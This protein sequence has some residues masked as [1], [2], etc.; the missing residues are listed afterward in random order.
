MTTDQRIENLEK[1]LAFARRLNRWLLAAVGLALGVW[2]LAGTFGPTMAAAPAAVAA[3][4]EVRAN[5]FVVEDENGKA[6][7]L[8]DATKEKVLELLDEKGNFLGALYMEKNGTRLY[9]SQVQT[10]TFMITDKTS[11]VPRIMMA[12][13]RETQY[14]Y[15]HCPF[16][17]V[18]APQREPAVVAVSEATRGGQVR[19]LNVTGQ[20]GL[21]YEARPKWY[22]NRSPTW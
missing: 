13:F 14:R 3:V 9:L 2:I 19:R 16:L 11:L 12:G 20:R 17:R 10:E 1:G 22:D 5:R 6:R 21:L 15:S 4:K 8:L 18:I 7:V